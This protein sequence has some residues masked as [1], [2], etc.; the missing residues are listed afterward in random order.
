MQI[1][2]RIVGTP[3]IALVE[4]GV[5]VQEVGEEPS[6]RDLACQLVEIEVTVFGQIV[7]AAFLF[8]YLYGENGRF[9]AAHAFVGAEQQFAHDAAPFGRGVCSVVDRR[10][11]HLVAAA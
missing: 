4:C 10:E 9:A 1:A 11:D 7:H 6:G 3:F 5:E 8:P 2:L